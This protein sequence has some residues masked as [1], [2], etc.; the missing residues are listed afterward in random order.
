MSTVEPYT[1]YSVSWNLTQRCNLECAHCYMS[2]FAG[3]DTRGELTT[4]EC[5]RVI[6]EIAQI[7]PN[8]FLI[9][10]GG[11]PLL[12]RDLWEIAAYAAEKRFTTVLGTNGVLLREREATL[13]RA[14]GVLG[15]SISLDS[16]DPAR[17]DAFRHLPGAWQGA[18]R[19]TRTL[20][21]AGL[22]FSLHMSVTDWNVGEVPAMIDLARELG[23]RVLNFFFLVR[24]GRGRDIRDI[25]AGA[26]ER[27]LT[28]LAKV[29]GVGA[30]ERFE[31]PWSTPIGRADGLLIRAKCAPHFRRILWEL[32]P[33]SPLL[34]NYAH[35]SC[36][37]GKYYCRITPEGD[38][39]PCP[40]MPVAAG[41]LR[42]ASFAALWREAPVFADLR[43]PALGG[44][45]GA[46]EFARVCG[47]C[48]C[49][50]YA[51]HG[52]YLAEDPACAYQP[53]AHGGRV[54]ELPATLTFGLP[55]AYELV[56][57]EAARARMQ[58]IPS[59]AR[60][61]VVKAVEAFA[62]RRGER[63]VTPELLTQARSMWGSR[64]RPQA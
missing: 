25:D 54:I 46:C 23:A 10:T 63:T 45:C 40:Y 22:D 59:F 5:R 47:G 17:H 35:G 53:G 60:G 56:W 18:V 51:T 61:M 43:E 15:A 6:D 38:V 24:T 58:A 50:A 37:A 62:R 4:A 3:A 11:E 57:D 30:A 21:D 28:Y 33:A 36:P 2:A 7:N 20:R 64:F 41:N 48:R 42:R 16:T 29:Q 52:D 39:T 31:D 13:M 34:Q 26:Y 49:R 12:R 14:H 32:N 55:E 19:A 8:V 27:I 1:A 44:R 9:L